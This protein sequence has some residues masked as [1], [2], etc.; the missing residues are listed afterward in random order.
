MITA[1]PEEQAYKVFSSM[2]DELKNRVK[3]SEEMD[4]IIESL[5]GELSM[6]GVIG[7][8]DYLAIQL[9]SLEGVK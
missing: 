4:P 5:K 6:K 8:V 7:A 9:K 2:M 1:H 3:T